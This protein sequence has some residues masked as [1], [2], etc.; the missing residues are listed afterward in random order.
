[1]SSQTDFRN[2]NSDDATVSRSFFVSFC[3]IAST[4]T[5]T[6]LIMLA[7]YCSFRLMLLTDTVN[8]LRRSNENLRNDVLF[9]KAA[10]SDRYEEAIKKRLEE[11]TKEENQSRDKRRQEEEMKKPITAALLYDVEELSEFAGIAD[12]KTKKDVAGHIATIGTFASQPFIVQSCTVED[13]EDDEDGEIDKDEERDGLRKVMLTI[14]FNDADDEEEDAENTLG[15]FEKALNVG[16][17]VGFLALSRILSEYDVRVGFIANRQMIVCVRVPE[18]LATEF[19][20]PIVEST[21]DFMEA[22]G[23]KAIIPLTAGV[24]ANFYEYNGSLFQYMPNGA[25]EEDDQDDEEEEET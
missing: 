15:F 20:P 19:I 18:S 2:K 21:E 22:V 13:D 23:D 12:E 4:L 5:I 11:Q 6:A 3:I 7:D 14:N 17:A 9:L 10:F 8:D 1:M 25:I 16:Y 24:I